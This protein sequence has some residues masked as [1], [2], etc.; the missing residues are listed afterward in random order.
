MHNYD[1]IE[2]HWTVCF[3]WVNYISIKLLC[4][5]LQFCIFIPLLPDVTICFLDGKPWT[6]REREQEILTNFRKIRLIWIGFWLLLYMWVWNQERMCCTLY[7]S[8]VWKTYI[9][10]QTWKIVW[11]FGKSKIQILL[12]VAFLI[13]T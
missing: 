10:D 6:K 4:F 8:S 1:Y 7:T 9:L 3:K 13:K 12:E 5:L 11:V 2:K